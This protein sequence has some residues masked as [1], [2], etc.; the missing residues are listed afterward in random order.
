MTGVVI[1]LLNQRLKMKRLS[2]YEDKE[3]VQMYRNVFSGNAGNLV[4]EDILDTAGVFD[5]ESANQTTERATLKA[6]GMFILNRCGI[7]HPDNQ[8][9]IVKALFT[10]VP[11][12]T[13]EDKEN[14]K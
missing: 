8:L 3:I 2:E 11:V 5:G 13:F 14:E 12:Q 1:F 6:F 9:D 7:N 4:L 10:A